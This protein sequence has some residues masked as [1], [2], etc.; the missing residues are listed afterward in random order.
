MLAVFTLL[1]KQDA[2]EDCQ[3]QDVIAPLHIPV[4]RSRVDF[5]EHHVKSTGINLDLLDSNSR[6]PLFMACYN[7]ELVKVLLEA[8]AN[9]M[10][11]P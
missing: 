9:P 5:L 6:T 10:R 11:T 4:S 7:E 3:S 8:R 1:L 2:D